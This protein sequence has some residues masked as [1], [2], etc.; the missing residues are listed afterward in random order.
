MDTL[1]SLSFILKRN[2]TNG[3]L[4]ALIFAKFLWLV[5][6]LIDELKNSIFSDWNNFTES[7]RSKKM[8][9][10]KIAF[11]SLFGRHA[12]T[13][14]RLLGQVDCAAGLVLLSWWALPKNVF[15][16]HRGITVIARSSSPERIDGSGPVRLIN[17]QRFR[18]KSP[19]LLPMMETDGKP[20]RATVTVDQLVAF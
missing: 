20:H 17:N 18:L 15:K 3:T 19:K 14:W 13:R 4:C 1:L 16:E 7:T 6:R 8:K 5:A 11:F 9:T 2:Q 12:K 10:L